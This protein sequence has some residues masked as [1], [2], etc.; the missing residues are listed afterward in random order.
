MSL[1]LP[2]HPKVFSKEEDFISAK[3]FGYSNDAEKIPFRSRMSAAILTLLL[4]MLV[5]A[6]AKELFRTGPALI[7]LIHL[8]FE[9]TILAHGALV[10][11]DMGP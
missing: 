9:P 8:V 1:Q 5:F 3:Q 4:A 11:T 7:A 2:P 6:A 10:T